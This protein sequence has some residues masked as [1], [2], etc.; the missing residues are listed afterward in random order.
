MSLIKRNGNY[1]DL[2]S[3]MNELINMNVDQFLNRNPF[4]VEPL[5]MPAV[6]IKETDNSFE[7]SL[8]APGLEKKDFK[9]E[10]DNNL[11][12]ISAERSQEKEEKEN[13]YTRKE[14]NYNSFM[15]SFELPPYVNAEAIDAQY[16]D[17]VLTLTLPKKEEAKTNRRKEISI[18]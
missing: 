4:F 18:E 15:R 11:L 2:R 13:A 6:N 14:Y 16:K 12:T 7:L 5:Q 8:A 17:G 1:S 10:V 9:V 3:T